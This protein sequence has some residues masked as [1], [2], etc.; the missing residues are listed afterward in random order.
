MNNNNGTAL[1]STNKKRGKT[2]QEIIKEAETIEEAVRLAAEELNVS[3]EKLKIEVLQEPQKKT[4]GLFGGMP[5]K[6]KASVND[7]TP[8]QAAVAF[9]K[10]ILS[11]M[12]VEEVAISVEEEESRCTLTLEGDDLGF[13]IG[14]RGET[15]DA[16]QYLTGLVANRVENSFYRVTINIGNYR[17][18]REKTLSGLA[19]KAAIQAAKTGRSTSLEPMNPYERRIIHTAVQKVDGATSYS[20]GSEPNRHVVIATDENNPVK[21]HESRTGRNRGERR[22]NARPER[23]TRFEE[24]TERPVREVRKFVPRSNPMN[25]AEDIAPPDRTKSETENSATLYGRIDL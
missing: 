16:L 17:E 8:S 19:R 18:K 20:V 4:F 6:I 21:N 24:Q 15:L 3:E 25:T 13:I 2:V 7:K 5:A 9:L 1:C 11:K 14:R 22:G 23:E 12:G 10:D